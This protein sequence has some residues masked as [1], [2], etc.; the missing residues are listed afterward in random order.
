MYVLRCLL[1]CQQHIGELSAGLKHLLLEL[2]Q[3]EAAK[4]AGKQARSTAVQL[5]TAYCTPAD[6]KLAAKVGLLPQQPPGS[7][8][9]DTHASVDASM[10]A[11]HASGLQEG[12]CAALCLSASCFCAAAAAAA[13]VLSTA[14]WLQQPTCSGKIAHA[15]YLLVLHAQSGLNMMLHT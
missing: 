9:A 3:P 13:A 6:A 2:I 4:A 14:G 1:Y 12:Y 5:F 7:V 10:I 8:P 15:C 11:L